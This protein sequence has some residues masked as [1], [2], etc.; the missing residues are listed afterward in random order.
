DRAAV[1]LSVVAGGVCLLAA[2]PAVAIGVIAAVVNWGSLDLAGPSEA[3][4]TLPY[5]MRHLLPTPL[6]AIGLGA[7]AAA[8]M[9][10]V[11]SSILSASSMAAWNVYRPLINPKADSH[12]L[13]RVVRWSV[14]GVGLL[15]TLLAL[16][17]KSVYALWF[18]CSDFVYCILFPQLV[19]ALFDP[20]AN[21]TG[22]LAGLAVSFVLR[23]GGGDATLGLPV[24]LP[25]PMLDPQQGLL[26]PFRTLSMV[27][28]LITIMLVSRLRKQ[29]STV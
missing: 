27:S 5:V 4:L 22:S 28:G 3:A 10:S 29:P 23:F 26:F 15:A 2:A 19:T 12:E 7:L 11:D 1:G 6:A 13:G 24:L 18:L 9:S 14:W 8:V 21:R 25:Y 17:V 16:A 20:K